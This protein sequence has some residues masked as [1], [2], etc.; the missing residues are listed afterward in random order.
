VTQRAGILA[1]AYTVVAVVGATVLAVSAYYLWL[2]A[3]LAG[4]PD[5]LAWTLPVAL[6]AGAIGATVCWVAAPGK[7]RRWGQ[8]I[9]LILLGGTVLCNI[10]AH[11]ITFGMLPVSAPLVVALAVVYPAT[12]WLL[13]HLALV[14]RTEQQATAAAVDE[15]IDVRQVRAAAEAEATAHAAEIA[16]LRAAADADRD[17]AQ[18]A[19]RDA[20]DARR[21]AED[22]TRQIPASPARQPA[23]PGKRRK[24]TAEQRQAWIAGQL[25]AGRDVAGSDVKREFPDAANGARD[26]ATVKARQAKEQHEQ[27]RPV[28]LVKEA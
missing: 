11:L 6:D 28:S 15:L 26:V 14:L 20:A 5:A 8:G 10:L 19:E 21:R 16:R 22:A 13:V 18:Q 7:A 23:R 27:R 2:F 1:L 24:S 3:S 17:A 4:M 12:L 9:A 25:D